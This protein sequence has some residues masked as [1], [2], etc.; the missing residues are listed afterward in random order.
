MKKSAGPDMEDGERRDPE[1]EEARAD[2][3]GRS[4]R[5]KFS[6]LCARMVEIVAAP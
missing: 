1:E 3:G 5:G 2:P 4:L 6:S